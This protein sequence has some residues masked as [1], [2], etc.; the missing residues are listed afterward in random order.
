MHLQDNQMLHRSPMTI[1]NRAGLRKY[2]DSYSMPPRSRRS[3]VLLQGLRNLVD[4]G[5]EVFHDL[6]QHVRDARDRLVV[7]L[8]RPAVLWS[9]PLARWLS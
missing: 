7:Q 1:N 8:L 9:R 2:F 3:R 4:L 6:R 5:L